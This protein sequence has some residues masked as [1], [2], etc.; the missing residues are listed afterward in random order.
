MKIKYPDYDNSILSLISSV[1]KHYGAECSHKSLSLLDEVLGIGYKNVV[2]MVFDGMG[3]NI[4]EKHLHK[5]GFFRSHVFANLSS[6]FPSTTTAALTTLESGL[7]PAEHGWLGWS[8]YFEEVDKNVVLFLNTIQGS[9][10]VPAA[11]YH[12]ANR[13]L[14][15]RRVWEK[16]GAATANEVQ[17]FIVSPYSQYKI[18][19]VEGI[20]NTVKDICAQ[21]G[22]KYI[23][24]Y[25]TNPDND[26]HL[27]GTDSE[28]AQNELIFIEEQ[29]EAM[30]AELE[31]SLVIITAD[32]GMTDIENKYL[33]DYPEIQKML[34]R[35][36]SIEA[37]AKAFF[38][39]QGYH[40]DFEKA[41]LKEFGSDY[42]L[43]KNSEALKNRLF[44]T[45][46]HPRVNGFIGDYLAVAVGRTNLE[47]KHSPL[48]QTLKAS[49][50]GLTEE[51]MIV[52]LIVIT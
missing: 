50:A 2:V 40:A 21:S 38:V 46:N 33:T 29:V 44:G 43:M 36:P 48:A 42:I 25:W 17:T 3:V 27:E 18:G 6:V 34:V 16:I 52:P 13:Y 31:D 1:L 51:E 9:G 5:N 22:R 24:A 7:S 49:H 4:L 41:F 23:Y 45:G 26:L 37:R 39:K 11:D 32:H 47:N 8:L 19:S 14:P 12:V 30:C 15:V 10:G 20:V 35:A 28:E